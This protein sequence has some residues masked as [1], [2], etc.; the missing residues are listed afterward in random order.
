MP[1]AY[2][3]WTSKVSRAEFEAKERRYLFE[4]VMAD[5]DRGD[6]KLETALAI[7]GLTDAMLEVTYDEHQLALFELEDDSGS[8]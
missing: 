4:V 7:L 2:D 1:E 5:V 6:L 3:P 8:A